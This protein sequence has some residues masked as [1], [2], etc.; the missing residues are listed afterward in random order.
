MRERQKDES[1]A[2]APVV[3]TKVVGRPDGGG[4]W[5]GKRGVLEGGGGQGQVKETLP[6]G[7]EV[8]LI[9]RGLQKWREETREGRAGRAHHER[10]PLRF[11]SH[12]KSHTGDDAIDNSW[13]CGEKPT[14]K[15]HS[16]SNSGQPFVWRFRCYSLEYFVRMN[17]LH[18]YSFAV[19]ANQ[20]T[21]TFKSL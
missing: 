2:G 8:Y 1:S 3:F 19:A 13:S 18:F 14:G 4:G 9:N 10:A 16:R 7:R 15:Q 12:Q 21:Q 6:D 5:R 20:A 17:F 11:T